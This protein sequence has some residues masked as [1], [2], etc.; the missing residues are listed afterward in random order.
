MI[1]E[2]PFSIFFLINDSSCCTCT[3]AGSIWRNALTYESAL[4]YSWKE[5][6]KLK[7]KDPDCTIKFTLVTHISYLYSGI[8][9]GQVIQAVTLFCIVI[10]VEVLQ[11]QYS[12]PNV[13]RV[14]APHKAPGILELC[15][16]RNV[17][18]MQLLMVHSLEFL[19][20]NHNSCHKMM[21]H[22]YTLDYT[23]R[24]VC[25]PRPCS[26]TTSGKRQINYSRNESALRT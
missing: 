11:Q 20:C 9:N 26:R 18:R 15:F 7:I 17:R 13:R 6:S 8:S 12:F 3:F 23:S 19:K 2:K 1:K 10:A 25:H 4:E 14:L 24:P 16:L 22:S 21:Q 5:V